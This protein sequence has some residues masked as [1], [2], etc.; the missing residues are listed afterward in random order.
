VNV[1]VFPSDPGIVNAGDAV[2]VLDPS[3]A[4]TVNCA[5]LPSAVS[6]PLLLE[7]SWAENWTP[8]VLDGT[9]SP[10]PPEPRLP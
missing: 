8:P 7:R 5:G 9:V 10:G 2:I 4:Y 1:S 6:E 3:G